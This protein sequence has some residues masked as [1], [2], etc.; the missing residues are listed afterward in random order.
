MPS[1]PTDEEL[2][3]QWRRGDVQAFNAIVV[4]YRPGLWSFASRILEDKE[5]AK[6]AL[7]EAFSNAF[8]NERQL[9]EPKEL[10]A[11][12]FSIVKRQC[13]AI[14]QTRRSDLMSNDVMDRDVIL[15]SSIDRDVLV[16]VREALKQL[17][18]DR[19]DAILLFEVAG[20]DREYVG[21]ILGIS[22][23]S[24]SRLLAQARRQMAEELRYLRKDT[25]GDGRQI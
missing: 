21:V 24:V 14:L 4:R 1:R 2:V 17:R 3:G 23:R 7:Q 6:D 13:F 22:T 19:R 18:D 15:E 12:L 9:R 20:Y 16:A 11:W 8:Y 25:S 5:E 10:K